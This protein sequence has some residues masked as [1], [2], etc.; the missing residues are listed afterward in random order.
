MKF[1][2]YYTNVTSSDY[3]Q[4]ASFHIRGINILENYSISGFVP[5]ENSELPLAF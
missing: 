2:N 5:L 4:E 1:A 3:F